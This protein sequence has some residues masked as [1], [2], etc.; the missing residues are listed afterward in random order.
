MGVLQLKLMHSDYTIIPKNKVDMIK[1]QIER[2]RGEP[3][4]PQSY[5]VESIIFN[6]D[7]WTQ[8]D[9]EFRRLVGEAEE[10]QRQAS[11]EVSDISA[12]SV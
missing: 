1:Q 4:S 8:W 12:A 9:D 2:L 11:T 10:E 6:L 3:L 7:L 5:L